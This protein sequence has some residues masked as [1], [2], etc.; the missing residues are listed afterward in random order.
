MSA[1]VTVLESSPAGGFN[2]FLMPPDRF[3]ISGFP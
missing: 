1:G 3:L 2:L